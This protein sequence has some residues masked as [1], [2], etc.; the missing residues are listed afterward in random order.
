MKNSF[1]EKAKRGEEIK[2]SIPTFSECDKVEN[3]LKDYGY[4]LT[5]ISSYVGYKPNVTF[6]V[7]KIFD[8]HYMFL[9]NKQF[10]KYTLYLN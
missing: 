4:S 1:I 9:L 2:M 7:T 6:T 3:T 8:N 5:S 10:M